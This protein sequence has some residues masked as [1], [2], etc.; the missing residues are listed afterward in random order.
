MMQSGAP[1]K[2]A[3]VGGASSGPSQ[4][5]WRDSRSSWATGTM[6]SGDGKRPRE[7][8][9]LYSPC[10]LSGANL[11][12]ME[13]EIWRGLGAWGSPLAHLWPQSPH[14]WFLPALPLAFF[15][16]STGSLSSPSDGAS[17]VRSCFLAGPGRQRPRSM[18]GQWG[19]ECRLLLLSPFPY[20]PVRW[21]C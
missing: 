7:P 8:I 1:S 17:L 15:P 14:S 21:D 6:R 5:L 19:P 16:P 4:L 18:L 10:P 3:G 11:G 20:I 9:P 13:T 12:V 2:L